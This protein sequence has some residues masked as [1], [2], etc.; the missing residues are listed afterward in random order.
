MTSLLGVIQVYPALGKLLGDVSSYWAG[1][2]PSAQKRILQHKMDDQRAELAALKRLIEASL[3]KK[4]T[5]TIGT[6]TE[7]TDQSRSLT[8]IE[9]NQLDDP[10]LL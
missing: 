4:E 1:E 10:E 6:Q 8:P 3:I 2:D 5:R 9:I 7:E